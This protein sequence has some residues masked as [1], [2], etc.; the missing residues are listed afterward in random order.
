MP[1][2]IVNVGRLFDRES[3][4]PERNILCTFAV[5]YGNTKD[6]PRAVDKDMNQCIADAVFAVGCGLEPGR[7]GVVRPAE[8]ALPPRLWRLRR[9][10]ARA[11]QRQGT[12]RRTVRAAD[13][14]G[15][16]MRARDVREGVADAV[17]F[18]LSQHE[19]TSW[20]L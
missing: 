14:G 19:V 17:D 15:R 12:A 7:E 4:T 6:A 18:W 5:R 1:I 16:L 8:P 13:A 10:D 2:R 9:R 3:D 11:E 20:G